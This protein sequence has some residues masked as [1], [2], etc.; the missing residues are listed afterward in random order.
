MKNLILV[1]LILAV[2]LTACKDEFNLPVYDSY[3]DG[4]APSFEI[5]YP[6]EDTT[7]LN[8]DSVN[9]QIICKD[10]YEIDSFLPPEKKIIMSTPISNLTIQPIGDYSDEKDDYNEKQLCSNL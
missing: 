10:D 7:I 2:V 8:K 9:I 4:D 6:N 5:L 3:V 1:G